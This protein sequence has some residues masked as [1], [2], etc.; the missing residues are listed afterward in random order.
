MKRSIARRALPGGRVAALEA[1]F[2]QMMSGWNQHIPQ[3]LAEI[4]QA[5]R[6]MAE[7]DQTREQIGELEAALQALTAEV[8]HLEGQLN[9][10][11][12]TRNDKG[13]QI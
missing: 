12:R 11:T 1:D 7:G 13:E 10:L 8:K 6:A 4:G 2:D 5:R 3:I 9:M